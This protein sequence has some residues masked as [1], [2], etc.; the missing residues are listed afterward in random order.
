MVVVGPLISFAEIH[1]SF[2]NY[3]FIGFCKKHEDAIFLHKNLSN[4]MFSFWLWFIVMLTN[5]L[6]TCYS[7]W[8]VINVPY[9]FANNWT[10]YLEQSSI[11]GF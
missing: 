1:S 4:E 6:I 11:L 5:N 2:I 9:N 10:Y 3:L 7:E 8:I